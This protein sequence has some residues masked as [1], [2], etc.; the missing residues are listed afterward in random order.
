[1]QTNFD[2]YDTSLETF[3]A[4][5]D[6]LENRREAVYNEIASNGGTTCKELAWKWHCS[7]NDISGRFTELLQAGRIIIIGKKHLPNNRNQMTC[8]RVYGVL[9]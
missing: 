1:M 2:D 7:P 9:K 3:H 8:N 5:K 4:I 6:D